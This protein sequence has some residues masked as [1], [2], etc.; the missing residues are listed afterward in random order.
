MQLKTMDEM[1]K[2]KDFDKFCV[3]CEC[4]LK[5]DPECLKKLDSHLYYCVYAQEEIF[6][7]RYS[8]QFLYWLYIDSPFSSLVRMIVN[9]LQNNIDEKIRTQRPG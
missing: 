8:I 1:R 9:T 2:N 7:T 6:K 5:A 3:T 4:H